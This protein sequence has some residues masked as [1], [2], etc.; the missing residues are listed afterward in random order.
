MRATN[1]SQRKAPYPCRR[2]WEDAVQWWLVQASSV[3]S[4]SQRQQK[5]RTVLWTVHLR[6]LGV[7]GELELEL[8]LE[9]GRRSD[10]NHDLSRSI[11]RFQISDQGLALFDLF[12]Q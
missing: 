8:E 9:L 5:G 3:F 4:L 10:H 2:R 1:D 6:T 11:F 7:W 12:E